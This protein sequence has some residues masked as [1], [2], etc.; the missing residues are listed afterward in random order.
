MHLLILSDVRLR[1]TGV[2]PVV[3]FLL[4]CTFCTLGLGASSFVGSRG[5]A[6]SPC[7]PVV[8][9][10]PVGLALGCGGR[11]GLP[12]WVCVGDWR[13]QSLLRSSEPS[14]L[15]A[16][17]VGWMSFGIPVVLTAAVRALRARSFPCARAQNHLLAGVPCVVLDYHNLSHVFRVERGGELREIFDSLTPA[18]PFSLT[19]G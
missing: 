10:P 9:S 6:A 1:L 18:R 4:P 3:P 19:G 8:A 16:L 14:W 12:L 11:A 13:I 5:I 2:E 15:D 17:G 7:F